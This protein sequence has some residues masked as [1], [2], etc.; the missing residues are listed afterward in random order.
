MNSLALQAK[1]PRRAPLAEAD[2]DVEINPENYDREGKLKPVRQLKAPVVPIHKG[3]LLY[4]TKNVRK[5]TDYINGMRCTVEATDDASQSVVVM[6][7][8][9]RR[10]AVTSL[11][12]E[13]LGGMRYYPLRPGYA[14][15]VMKFQGTE[16]ERVVVYLDKPH[17]PAA[18]YTA[19]S[20]VRM[21]AQ[22]LIGGWVTEHHFTPAR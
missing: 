8:T 14:S 16:L 1:F 20:R 4:L 12:D 11:C 15:T 7:A 19:M 2:G 13:D 5:D 10:V 3:M 6:T 21:G 22:C 9:G 17:V 18:A